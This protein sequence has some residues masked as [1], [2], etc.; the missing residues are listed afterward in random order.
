MRRL[1]AKACSAA[2]HDP[3]LPLACGLFLFFLIF[4]KNAWVAE[5]A[6]IVFRVVDQ[7]FAGNGLR[8]N[9][10]ERVQVYT[11]VLWMFLLLP[12][13]MFSSDLFVN[14]IVIAAVL[15]AGTLHIAWRMI[16]NAAWWLAAVV[17]L[18]ASKGFMD[19]SSGGLENP[20]SYLVVALFALCYL[21]AFNPAH[22]KP[23]AQ[24]VSGSAA[25]RDAMTRLTLVVSAVPLVR[26]D[27][28]LLVAP[29]Y[30]YAW[31]HAPAMRGSRIRGRAR[32][33]LIAAAPLLAWSLFSLFY[34]GHPLP[35]TALSKLNMQ[36]PR[37]EVLSMG[38]G[39]LYANLRGDP[40]SPLLLLACACLLARDRVARPVGLGALLV[41][42]YS[43]W[44]GGDYMLGRFLGVP[45]FLVVLVAAALQAR[46]GSP[47]PQAAARPAL[48]AAAAGLLYAALIP[49]SPLKSPLGYSRAWQDSQVEIAYRT[50]DEQ[51][52]YY[53][54][55]S[56]NRMLS[57]SEFHSY[58]GQVRDFVDS[59][60]KLP[61]GTLLT[62][63]GEGRFIY[64]LGL[65]KIVVAYTGLT[66]PFLAR[67]PFNGHRSFQLQGEERRRFNPLNLPLQEDGYYWWPGHLLRVMPDGYPEVVVDETARL[68]DEG[69][70][71]YWEKVRLVTQ[72][73]LLDWQRILTAI[74]LSFG[75]Y[76]HLLASVEGKEADYEVRKFPWVAYDRDAGKWFIPF[77]DY[78]KTFHQRPFSPTDRKGK[79]EKAPGPA[80]GRQ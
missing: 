58:Y 48:M 19:Y 74:R 8:W 56:L 33:A 44:I 39:W 9:P 60:R 2:L 4:I 21:Q 63:F 73:D 49:Y 50:S 75:A 36:L 1:L 37:S 53:H 28:S 64:L 70:Q 31:L 42:G 35:N 71:Q 5:D 40:I 32:L 45:L 80:I 46:K 72:G 34:Y 14:S 29:A 76:D 20:L 51:R 22:P 6:F 66:D 15:C 54:Y 30:A 17:V 26:H 43:V 47:G 55:L 12:T 41:L 67:L 25:G 52:R 79:A 16:G 11:S 65:D 24:D 10:H 57:D 13:R 59:Y 3:R 61:A 23:P 38:V 69:L 7:F 68:A 27:L 77:G 78:N 62:S 18:T